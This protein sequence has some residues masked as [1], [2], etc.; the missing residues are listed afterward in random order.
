[1]DL[2]IRA[3][4][5]NQ[6]VTAV[7]G[8]VVVVFCITELLLFVCLFVCWVICFQSQN[9]T[10]KLSPEVAS[11]LPVYLRNTHLRVFAVFFK[12][13]LFLMNGI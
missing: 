10:S 3:G 9:E 13:T 5:G 4:R 12:I 2:I 1:M 11:I 7:F 6:N 8:A